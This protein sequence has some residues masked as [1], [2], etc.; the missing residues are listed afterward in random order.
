MT[1]WAS[2]VAEPQVAKKSLEFMVK[3]CGDMGVGNCSGE[4][5]LHNCYFCWDI[6]FISFDGELKPLFRLHVLG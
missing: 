5:K 2:L 4:G 1:D 6:P 3:V